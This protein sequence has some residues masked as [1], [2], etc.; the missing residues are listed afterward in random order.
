V[1]FDVP[2]YLALLDSDSGRLNHSTEAHEGMKKETAET[3]TR[4]GGTARRGYVA[5][6]ALAK[7]R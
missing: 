1:E 6:L 3:I 2:R 5:V 4:L 7:R